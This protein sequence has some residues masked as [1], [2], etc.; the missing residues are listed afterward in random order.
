M[1]PIQTALTQVAG[2]P[3][4][5]LLDY[6][7]DNTSGYDVTTLYLISG[8]YNEIQLQR[9]QWGCGNPGGCHWAQH[10]W[11]IDQVVYF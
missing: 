1:Q 10:G 3:K 11:G 6:S 8:I 9:G 2:A 4:V 5:I 7:A